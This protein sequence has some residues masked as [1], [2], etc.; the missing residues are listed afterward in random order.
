MFEEEP[1]KY[2]GFHFMGDKHKCKLAQ[3]YLP[4]DQLELNHLLHDAIGYLYNAD[5]KVLFGFVK[6]LKMNNGRVIINSPSKVG[7][8]KYQA[9]ILKRK[10]DEVRGEGNDYFLNETKIDFN[11]V[12]YDVSI[13][14]VDN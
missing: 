3:T 7:K 2:Y 5:F 11:F 13:I 4:V 12:Q 8:E 14:E 6:E 1:E 9:F 10:T